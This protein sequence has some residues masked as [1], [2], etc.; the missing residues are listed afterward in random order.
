M[1]S[2]PSGIAFGDNVFVG[3][4][5]IAYQPATL[6][7]AADVSHPGE[8]GVR[9]SAAPSRFFNALNAPN[10]ARRFQS[11]IPSA[12]EVRA[13]MA[14]AGTRPARL[15]GEVNRVAAAVEPS[16]IVQRQLD[17]S[18]VDLTVPPFCQCQSAPS[19][20]NVHSNAFPSTSNWNRPG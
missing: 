12:S 16:Q 5:D 15:G 6:A 10:T 3:Q 4:H 20:P 13:P 18:V 8:V 1:R 9:C 19:V 11:R 17:V 2:C 14:S 7:R